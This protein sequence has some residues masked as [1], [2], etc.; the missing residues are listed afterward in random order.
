MLRFSNVD[1]EKLTILFGLKIGTLIKLETET[2]ASTLKRRQNIKVL[3][4]P[5]SSAYNFTT[6]GLWLCG[7]DGLVVRWYY[8]SKK[9]VND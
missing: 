1:D 7:Y 8:G 9:L 3:I 6:A 4:I 5:V 2:S